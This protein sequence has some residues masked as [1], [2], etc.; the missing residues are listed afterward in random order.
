M[1]TKRAN[2]EGTIHHER[3]RGRWVGRLY[4]NGKRRKVTAR[5]KVDL[6]ARMAELRHAA[7]TGE[8]GR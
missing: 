2:G 6:L 5:T 7:A 3:E 8:V 4:V 1:A